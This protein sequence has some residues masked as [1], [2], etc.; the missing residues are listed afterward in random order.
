MLKANEYAVG[1]NAFIRPCAFVYGNEEWFITRPN[2][3]LLFT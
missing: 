2:T 3:A 1:M